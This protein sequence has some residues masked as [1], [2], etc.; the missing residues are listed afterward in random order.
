MTDWEYFIRDLDD[1]RIKSTSAKVIPSEILS[2]KRRVYLGCDVYNPKMW[3]LLHKYG[4]S[5]AKFYWSEIEN[6]L[7]HETLHVIVGHMEGRKAGKGIDF[8]D[9]WINISAPLE[10]YL[11]TQAHPRKRRS[12]P[13]RR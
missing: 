7:N 11:S 5:V 9:R 2:G 13:Y 3:G 6:I 4:H 10:K 12:E 1:E 8:A